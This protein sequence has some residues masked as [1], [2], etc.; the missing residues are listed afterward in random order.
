MNL[1]T[2][3]YRPRTPNVTIMRPEHNFDKTKVTGDVDLGAPGPGYY[4]INDAALAKPLKSHSKPVGVVYHPE[5]QPKKP[6]AYNAKVQVEQESKAAIGPGTYAPEKSFSYVSHRQPVL[7]IMR[8]ADSKPTAHMRRK[9]Y[10]EQKARDM[11][12]AHDF[13]KEAN[14]SQVL[15]RAPN[16]TLAPPKWS[17]QDPR[18]EKILQEH[19]LSKMRPSS[20]GDRTRGRVKIGDLELGRSFDDLDAPPRR[21]SDS[22]RSSGGALYNSQD[23]L[24]RGVER[25]VPTGAFMRAEVAARRST[26]AMR[27]AKPGVVQRYVPAVFAVYNLSAE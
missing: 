17:Q 19:R 8:E 20:A 23:R 4:Q 21:S 1:D 26:S 27:Q 13:L 24:F 12:E 6:L 15:T 16:V 25:R 10:F 22:P 7:A 14:L 3:A 2:L 9:R 11:R 5:S 18:R